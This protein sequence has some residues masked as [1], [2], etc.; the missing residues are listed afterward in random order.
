MMPYSNRPAFY[1]V[2][3]DG[4]AFV[5]V[6]ADDIAQQV[7]GYSLSST[8]PISEDGS[9][10]LP[11]HIKGFFDDLAAQMEAAI[12]SEPISTTGI[13]KANLRSAAPNRSPSLPDSVGPLLTTTWDQGQ[14][15]NSLCPEDANGPGGHAQTGCVATAMAQIVKYWSDPTPGRGTHSY[16][17]NYGELTV[18]YEAI[19]YDFDDMPSAL[20]ELSTP[21][22]I[23]A[24]AKL[25]Y[26]CGVASNMSYGAYESSS[27]DVDARAG[28]INFFRFSPDLS[29]AERNTFTNDEWN[30]LL[31]ENIAANC[32]MIYSGHGNNGGHSFVCDGYNSN[33]YFHF[34]FGWG[35]F[36]DG[37]YLTTSVTPSDKDF[38]SSQSALVGIVPDNTGKVILGQMKG[39]STFIVDEPLEF[40][41]L[42]GH[43]SYTV[44]N[45]KTNMFTSI[46]SFVSANSTKQL[47]LD[48]LFL[49][50]QEIE[51]S[52]NLGGMIGQFKD[53]VLTSTTADICTPIVST[54]SC[55]TIEYD[56]SL[57]NEGFCFLIGQ[58]NSC[59]M[60]SNPV[61]YVVNDS[62]IHLEWQ[63]R[64]NSDLWE[65]EYGLKGFTPG[66]G[67]K[68]TSTTTSIE[69]KGLTY[70]KLY[71]FY[72]RPIC[73]PHGKKITILMAEYWQDAVTQQPEG[74]S[75][76]GCNIVV[77]TAEGLAWWAATIDECS[78]FN[79]FIESDIDLSGKIWRPVNL[80]GASNKN[81]DGRGHIISNMTII[82]PNYDPSLSNGAGFFSS[83]YG[84]TIQDII[85]KN[86]SITSHAY[87]AGTLAGTMHALQIKNCGV[88][89]GNIDANSDQ[90]GGLIGEMDGY[91]NK[92][93]GGQELLNCFSNC[94]ITST[95]EICYGTIGGMV[96][97]SRASI[98]KNCYSIGL[99]SNFAGWSGAFSA[100]N[101]QV[102]LIN[103]YR[104]NWVGN[105]N[106]DGTS[107]A[108]NYITFQINSTLLDT[109]V[110]INDKACS[111]LLTALNEFVK[112]ENLGWRM[113]EADK[114]N[115]NGGYP[116][117]GNKQVV[118][119]P[120][121]EDLSGM[122]LIVDGLNTLRLSW[123]SHDGVS[124]WKIKYYDIDSLEST[125]TILFVDT[126]VKDI[127]GLTLGK[128]YKIFV[129]PICNDTI[130]GGWGQGIEFLFELP[131][132][133]DI[134]M[135]IPDGYLED[136]QGNVF[137]NSA[138]GLAWL[139]SRV[140]GLNGQEPYSFEGKKITIQSDID[141]DGYRWM[142]IGINRAICFNGNV[143]GCNKTIRNIH[144][145]ENN[146]FVG[147]FGF[148]YLGKF[149]NIILQNANVRGKKQVGGLCGSY[150]SGYGVF[151]GF[152][153]DDVFINNCH[154][155]NCNI[156]GIYEAG[157]ILG[158]TQDLAG[159]KIINCSTSGNI[160]CWQGAGGIIG[161]WST[162]SEWALY[163]GIG[164]IHNCYS[165]ANI[166]DY[167]GYNFYAGGIAAYSD[168]DVQNCY[169]IGEINTQRHYT[170]QLL[171][172]LHAGTASYLYSPAN[173]INQIG[174][175]YRESTSSNSSSFSSI[176]DV[177]VLNP[178]ISIDGLLFTDLL[179]ALNAWVDA[180]DST[181]IYRHWVADTAY[182]NGGFPIFAPM[183]G[184]VNGDNVVD[185]S[186]YIGVANYILGHAPD[187]FNETAADVN[188][189]GKID[190]SDYIG[191][192]NII[193]KGKP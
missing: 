190:I 55:F 173:N 145:N 114:S 78:S 82:E 31:R 176:Q 134:V 161:D 153:Y 56:G 106:I 23:S 116:I 157:G 126:N 66:N 174:K 30:N 21:Q 177:I 117:L 138:E 160:Y 140:N 37:W 26:N 36:C 2:N 81:I 172:V 124:S 150:A 17:T 90:I 15:Y 70:L 61:A 131:Y 100:Y 147:L 57:I 33:D 180:N 86:P 41:H 62:T 12:E 68:I 9:V 3:V 52:Y 121:V 148:V 45:H 178:C 89:N 136:A 152:L 19:T 13:Y 32:P 84:D 50:D 47:V 179:S 102:S 166:Y 40:Y 143:D 167:N 28:L 137:I 77:T 27:N 165:S 164:E 142:P 155:I 158:G 168:G 14:Y 159:I 22:Q 4:G 105:V 149:S 183:L 141:L 96:G 119:C 162:G 132:W 122:N 44:T 59:R 76:N 11:E 73:L 125:S 104:P 63:E 112:S 42:L 34:N 88:I 99:I 103:C 1:I 120:N 46:V 97:C 83:F 53:Y 192:A 163:G 185:I 181:G 8:W 18:N 94:N 175:L 186:D 25:M 115:E 10:D 191:V 156:Y 154:S 92:K 95:S 39:T 184:D 129:K 74:Y 182:I 65:I 60:V 151:D 189:D 75:I 58:E 146:D 113:W 144:I 101:D 127:Q 79:L 87:S 35:G 171:G 43:N 188:N 118:A 29:Y 64:G 139:A 109:T 110:I 128:T 169:S 98:I 54:Q 48:A 49:D 69:I 111:D 72:I 6:S 91:N 193:L 67:T 133:T 187:G 93:Q 24:V 170:G 51:V 107:N 71:D 85:F 38:S 7:L 5:L 20:T 130:Y 80:N 123:R 135:S 16:E 108:M